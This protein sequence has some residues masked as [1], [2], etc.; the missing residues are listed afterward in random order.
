MISS[1][2]EDIEQHCGLFACRLFRAFRPQP[3]EVVEGRSGGVRT[4]S[5]GTGQGNADIGRVLGRIGAREYGLCDPVSS[6]IV[7]IQNAGMRF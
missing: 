1:L 3:G 2:Y 6:F 5:G 7:R 4:V